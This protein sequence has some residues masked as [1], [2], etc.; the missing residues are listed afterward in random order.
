MKAA[1]TAEM[2]EPERA[3]WAEIGAAWDAYF[4]ADEQVMTLLNSDGATGIAEATANINDGATGD[5]WDRLEDA[6]NKLETSVR[7]RMETMAADAAGTR[8]TSQAIVVLAVVVALAA[9]VLLSLRTT[10]SVVRP[11]RV[12]VTALRRLADGDLTVR[13]DMRG[14]DELAE[15]GA[16]LDDTASALRSTVGSLAGHAESMST[17]SEQLSHT[18]EEIAATADETS[19]Q[20]AVVARTAD[21]V[22]TNVDAVA[23]GSREM[24]AAIGR[25]P[26][27]RTRPPPWRRRPSPPPRPPPRASPASAPPPPRSARSRGS[28]RPSRSRP[29]C[30]R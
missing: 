11:L 13:A 18:A 21:G 8:R 27:T 28:S 22:S 9:A 2:T 26:A 6:S 24:S 5:A 17:A 29:T 3:L 25:S 7:G 19:A 16:A 1:P 15:L 14:R 10:R 20:A 23:G 4:A 30:W 12:V